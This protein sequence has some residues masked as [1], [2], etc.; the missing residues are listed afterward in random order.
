[1]IVGAGYL[2]VSSDKVAS[3]RLT[4]ARRGEHVCRKSR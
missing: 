3:L 4:I 1:M 2:I